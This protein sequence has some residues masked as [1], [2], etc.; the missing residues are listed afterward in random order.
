MYPCVGEAV[1][2]ICRVCWVPETTFFSG[3]HL[4]DYFEAE[5]RLG[6]GAGTSVY[7]KVLR[8][9]KSDFFSNISLILRSYATINNGKY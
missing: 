4:K 7:L 6:L 5:S 3:C 1:P 2:A 8:C 9:K